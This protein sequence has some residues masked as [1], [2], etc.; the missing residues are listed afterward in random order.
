M[1]TIHELRYVLTNEIERR[2]CK[3]CLSMWIWFDNGAKTKGVFRLGTMPPED[4][5]HC[6]KLDEE[7]SEE[8]LLT[9][10]GWI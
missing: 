6:E 1:P 8:A 2:Q 4:C 3:T 10:E 5:S 7:I 9:K